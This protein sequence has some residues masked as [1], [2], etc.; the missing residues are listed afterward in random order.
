MYPFSFQENLV[1]ENKELTKNE[2]KEK[3]GKYIVHG[4][5]PE[6][7]IKGIDQKDYLKTLF[8]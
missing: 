6:P 4:G 5:F 2:I 1:L 7:L 8:H 3:L